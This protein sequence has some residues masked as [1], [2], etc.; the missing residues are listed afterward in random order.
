MT[1]SKSVR[2]RSDGG[3]ARSGGLLVVTAHP[4]DEALI[5][6]GTLL[7]C[8]AAAIPTAVV[9]LTRG[10]EG[11]ISDPAVA[12]RETL[13]LVRLRELHAACAELA[14]SVVRC[15]AHP[16]CYLPWSGVE[17]ISRELVDLV[18]ELRPQAVIT[19]GE[20][21]LYWHPD[22]ISTLECMSAALTQVS[23]PPALYRSAIPPAWMEEMVREL[24]AREAP[25]DLWGIDP[26]DFGDEELDAPIELDV[27]PFV[28]RKL[29]AL[30]CH[31][32][33][34]GPGHAFDSIPADLAERFLGTE[35]FLTDTPDPWLKDAV[36]RGA[37][38][39]RAA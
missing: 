32:S 35:W 31:R 26:E 24:Q 5:A 19:F 3:R 8:A 30:R 23:S 33:Q 13:P 22:H 37:Q 39:A 27:R 29:R 25:A 28:R 2:R 11:P 18:E 20:D 15:H 17:T 7:A 1:A 21:G 10:E 34:I 4:D 16:D 6:G 36:A 38:S 12:T 9:C 14:V